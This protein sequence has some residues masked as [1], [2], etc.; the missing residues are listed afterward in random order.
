MQNT[1]P[2][3]QYKVTFGPALGRSAG[4]F[5]GTSQP[6]SEMPT[7]ATQNSPEKATE[8]PPDGIGYPRSPSVAPRTG[9]RIRAVRLA[10]R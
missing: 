5:T 3:R 2:G 6:R 7:A 1:Q 10:I 4:A 8:V 9:H